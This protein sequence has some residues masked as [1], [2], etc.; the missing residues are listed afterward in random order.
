V[1]FCRYLAKAEAIATSD[2][3]PV[4]YDCVAGCELAFPSMIDLDHYLQD[5]LLSGSQDKL[6]DGLS[7]ILYWGNYRSCAPCT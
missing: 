3:P 6:K 1:A 7:G 5:L 2:Y 4:T